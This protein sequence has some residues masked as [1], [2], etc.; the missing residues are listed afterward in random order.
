MKV[1]EPCMVNPNS[2][3]SLT[4]VLEHVQEQCQ[5]G[6]DKDRKW[7]YTWC[8]SVPYLIGS[9][10]QEETLKCALCG[11]MVNRTDMTSHQEDKHKEE[12]AEFEQWFG[13]IFLRPGPGHIELNMACA[14]MKLLWAPYMQHFAILLGFRSPRAQDV[15]HRGV[16]HHRSRQILSTLLNALAKELVRPFVIHQREAKKETD[17]DQFFEWYGSDVK[18]H[19]YRFAWSV[20]FTY[21]LAFQLYTQAVRKNHHEHMMAAR[22]SFAPLF[23]GRNHPRYRELHL[24]DMMDRVQSPNDLREDM[25][26]SESFSLSG[27]HNKGQGVDFLHEEVN[28][29]V[30]SLLPPGAVTADLWTRVCRKADSLSEMKDKCI[31]MT[32]YQSISGKKAPKRHDHEE[33]MIRRELRQAKLLETPTESKD[34]MTSITGDLLDHDLANMAQM[35]KSSYKE[36]KEELVKN[37]K[38]GGGK[39]TQTLYITPEERARGE[40]MESKTKQVIKQEIQKLISEYGLTDFS[41]DQLK[42]SSKKDDYLKLYYEV[43]EAIEEEECVAEEEEE[44]ELENEQ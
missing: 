27:A 10:V 43:Q 42:Q 11:E 35:M 8:D 17:I 16:D 5:I 7:V 14:I 24:R 6:D 9:K 20:C 19:N 31:A 21:L 1:A 18:D 15:V 34:L 41:V 12:E 40:S 26:A 44:Q 22:A 23:Y 25:A 2:K 3:G 32:G 4:C 29:T 38:F 13:G 33:T 36:Y 30:K 28:R 37:G 39:L